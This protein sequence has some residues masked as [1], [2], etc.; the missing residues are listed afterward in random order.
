M[1]V[2]CLAYYSNLKVEG[3]CSPTYQT[4]VLSNLAEEVVSLAYTRKVPNSK[5]G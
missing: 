1:L 3:I 4:F 5:A 2:S